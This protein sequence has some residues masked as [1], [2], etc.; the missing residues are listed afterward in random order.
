M[1]EYEAPTQLYRVLHHR[2]QS[3]PAFLY[4]NI[5]YQRSI[6]RK[7]K[8]DQRSREDKCRFSFQ[9][10]QDPFAVSTFLHIIFQAVF[11][12]EKIKQIACTH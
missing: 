6:T 4:R 7:K 2:H 12:Y 11:F 9:G 1:L 10:V 3:D 5:N 8:I